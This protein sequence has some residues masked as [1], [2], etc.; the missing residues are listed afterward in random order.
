M[1]QFAVRSLGWGVGILAIAQLPVL[2]SNPP[3]AD[4]QQAIDPLILEHTAVRRSLPDQPQLLAVALSSR[5]LRV[6]D[7]GTDV[8]SLQRFLGRNGLYPFAV[9]GKYG[10]DTVEAV[11]TYQRIRG[12]SATG[13]A[14]EETLADMD[15]DFLPA[16]T[17]TAVATPTAASQS[18]SLLSGNLVP[19]STGSD[20]IALQQ[21]LNRFGIPVFVDGVYGF[22]TQQGVR[23]Y[24]RVQGLNVTGNADSATLER[25]GFVAPNYPYVAAVIA[26]ESQLASVREFFPDA[27][28]DRNRRGRFINIGSFGDR[29]PAE[30]RAN[31]ATARG[32]STRVLY[33]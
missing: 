33:R 15:F 12:L 18:P 9:D 23:T 29:F 30:A 17:P 28:V 5:T 7:F 13:I 6:G 16:A 10:Q 2:A 21:R 19:G 27:F 20:V 4:A 22:E 14:D 1:K 32:F 11:A 25:M 31:A 26:D 3:S 24:Q 8:R